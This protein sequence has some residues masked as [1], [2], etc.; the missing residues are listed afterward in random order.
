VFS[1]MCTGLL[2]P[3]FVEYALRSGAD[4]VLVT[5]CREGSCAYRFGTRWTEERLT[6]QREPH[7]RPTVPEERLRLAWA[8]GHEMSH[9][10]ATLDDFRQYLQS[11]GADEKR[12]RPYT[13]RRIA[14]HG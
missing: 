6:R 4:G 13:P 11:L 2:P 3:S 1:L 7:L 5:G 14:H 8:D 9:L 12:L 10:K